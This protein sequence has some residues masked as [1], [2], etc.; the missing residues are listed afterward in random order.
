MKITN[1]YDQ[2]LI[3]SKKYLLLDQSNLIYKMIYSIKNDAFDQSMTRMFLNSIVFETTNVN[4]IYNN[5]C[6]STLC[7]DENISS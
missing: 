6:Y 4:L 1:E 2:S 3:T 7:W 5:C